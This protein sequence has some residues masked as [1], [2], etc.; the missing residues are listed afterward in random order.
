[1]RAEKAEPVKRKKIAVLA[2]CGGFLAALLLLVALWAAG[3]IFPTARYDY[4]QVK[5]TD[6]EDYAY[7]QAH[8]EEL[9]LLLAPVEGCVPVLPT[10]QDEQSGQQANLV[11]EDGVRSANLTIRTFIQLLKDGQ[12]AAAAPEYPRY[13]W[14]FP[15]KENTEGTQGVKLS[16]GVELD[17]TGQ[18]LYEGELHYSWQTVPCREAEGG[19]MGFIFHPEGL[20]RLLEEQRV[21]SVRVLLPVH[22]YIRDGCYS[23]ELNIIYIESAT[24]AYV[25]PYGV[26]SVSPD[27]I[28]D[29]RVYTVEE[30]LAA[31]E[32]MALPLE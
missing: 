8:Q 23:D 27:E 6:T 20:M 25:V 22:T 7:V 5:I 15:V 18:P 32:P 12:L 14:F 16:C 24:G 2:V 21:G 17:E 29:A 4:R 9:E 3:V 28:K 31:V 11:L 26:N 13:I 19:L 10:R 1:M 30:F